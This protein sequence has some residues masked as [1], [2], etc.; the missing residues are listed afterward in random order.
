MTADE[1]PPTDPV[2]RDDRLFD[3]LNRGEP[4]PPDHPADDP[5]T[6]L[7]ADWRTEL[8]AR[9]EQVESRL[10]RK[11]SGQGT[12]SPAAPPTAAPP[13]RRLRPAAT[14]G[15]AAPARPG[16]R[17]RTAFAGAALSLLTVV[18][19][20]WLGA[21]RAEP[22]GLFWPVTELVYAD[23]AESLVTER[24]I[25]RI[26]DE[27]RQD[28]ADRR[29]ADARHH[30]ERAAVLLGSL[31]D[32]ETVVRLRGD[33]DELRRLLP[34][35]AA[36]A[37]APPDADIGTATVPV[38][39]DPDGTATVPVPPDTDPATSSVPVPPPDDPAASHT[40]ARPTPTAPAPAGRPKK[41]AGGAPD[42]RPHTPTGGP[43][44]QVPPAPT[45]VPRGGKPH[46]DG[47]PVTRP[48]QPVGAPSAP[49][50]ATLPLPAGPDRAPASPS[51]PGSAGQ[52]S[53]A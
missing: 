21:A 53:G 46:P 14:A 52:P 24:E 47:G 27:A 34:S 17:R 20:L 18:G 9:S 13:A 12:G 48:R 26:L 30:L 4:P 19:G 45:A 10:E 5:V 8:V 37:P 43:P 49:P 35:P 41:P 33:I 28:L 7:L 23:R 3:A 31:G 51:V 25:G 1:P 36:T 22:G 40:P 50:S 42:G 29:Y 44:R 32:D 2:L 39:S 16:G 11:Q 6:A 15:L 38:P